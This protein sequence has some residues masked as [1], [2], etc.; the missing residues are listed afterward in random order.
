MTTQTTFT[1]A[2]RDAASHNVP[3]RALEATD[4]STT[5]VLCHSGAVL[6][7]QDIMGW[8]RSIYSLGVKLGTH[9]KT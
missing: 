1:L 9:V 8:Y 2:Y 7:V 6:S 5:A 4:W 3:P